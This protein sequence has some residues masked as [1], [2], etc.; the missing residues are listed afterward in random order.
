MLLIITEVVQCGDNFLC[1]LSCPVCLSSLFQ[2][3]PILNCK[4]CGASFYLAEI[5][6]P[7]KRSGFRYLAGTKRK[8]YI[9]KKVIRDLLEAQG[10]ACG[11]CDKVLVDGYHIDHIIPLRVG[12]TSRKENLCV[13]CP[14]C[15]FI[16]GSK[17]FQTF[18]AKK[19]YIL[20][21]KLRRR[22]SI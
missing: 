22:K 16:A 18:A 3:F 13:T 21:K 19:N 1:H 15:N 6:L 12:G 7:K 11:Y 14:S 9:N 5:E 8:N 10:R 2:V 4:D 17:E 20:T